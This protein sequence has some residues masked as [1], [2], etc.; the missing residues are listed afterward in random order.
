VEL[1][2]LVGDVA[3]GEAYFVARCASCHSPIGDLQGIGVRIADPKEL[4]NTWVRGG[5]RGR[6][7]GPPSERSQARVFVTLPSGERVEG[8]L[9]RLDDFYVALVD[10]DGRRRS[11]T[12]RGPVPTVEV[13]DPMA[14]H[15]ALLPMY[16]D[17]DI[18]NVTAYLAT[19]K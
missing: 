19:L 4:Q 8:R 11:F 2:V 14:G 10:G 6:A 17:S 12:R 16:A 18:H 1:N 13:D 5:A 9:E 3:A 15:T 7:A